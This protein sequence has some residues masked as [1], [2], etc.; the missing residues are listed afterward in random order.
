MTIWTDLL[1]AIE[2]EAIAK[3]YTGTLAEVGIDQPYAAELI[4]LLELRS[5][6]ASGGG[7]GG[8]G[9]VVAS[10]AHVKHVESQLT[11]PSTSTNSRN[12]D[13]Y[14]KGCIQVVVASINTSVTLR[15]EGSNDNSNW[16]NLSTSRTDTTF[17]ANGCYAFQFDSCPQHVRTTFVN[18]AGGTAATIDVITRFSA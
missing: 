17:T 1:S 11:A 8:G 5:K 15:V 4:T 2:A 18:E 14:S 10:A 7:G 16:F 6:L 12:M 9:E 13:G 3:G